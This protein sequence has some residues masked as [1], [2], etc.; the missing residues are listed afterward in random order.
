MTIDNINYISHLY[1]EL[2]NIFNMTIPLLILIAVFVG[3]YFL[4]SEGIKPKDDS[5][6][7]PYK[8]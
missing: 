5:I 1:C 4:Q 3:I 2:K 6:D 7:N 8:K